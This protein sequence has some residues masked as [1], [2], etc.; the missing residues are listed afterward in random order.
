MAWAQDVVLLQNWL[1]SHIG[2]K[3]QPIWNEL[4]LSKYKAPLFRTDTFVIFRVLVQPFP[5]WCK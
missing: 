1:K 4:Q 5:R 2:D 3:I